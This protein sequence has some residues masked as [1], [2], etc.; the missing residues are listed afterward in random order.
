MISMM[1]KKTDKK[2]FNDSGDYEGPMIQMEH[3]KKAFGSN[4]VLKDIN[5][6]V[7]RGEVLVILG[8]SGSGKSTL[9]RCINRLEQIN[10]GKII[11]EGV[12]IYDKD[13]DVH[14]LRTKVGMVFQQFNL[15]P[16]M[17]VID[18][19]ILSPLKVK[20]ENA[21]VAKK[22][23]M[24]LLGKVGLEDKYDSFPHELSGG[25][26]QRVAIARA[27]A[28]NPDVMLFDEVTSALDPELVKG[29]LETMKELAE[30]GMTMLV[31]THEMGFAKEVA[32]RVIFMDE[33]YILESGKPAEIF[34]NPKHERTKEFISKIL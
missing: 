22:R 31:V 19:I 1:A 6:D 20:G 16:H 7:K 21:D 28:M 26:Q 33:G 13:T 18:N 29:V 14:E 5:L 27:L 15:F 25:Q 17:K 12:D 3:I 23:A 10:G 30:M 34:D 32:D 2:S 9:I 11:V 24:E 8:P 4:V